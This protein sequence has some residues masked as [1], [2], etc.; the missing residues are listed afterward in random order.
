MLLCGTARRQDR[1]A[2][3]GQLAATAGQ[4]AMGDGQME[5]VRRAG[6]R[7]EEKGPSGWLWRPRPAPALWGHSPLGMVK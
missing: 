6:H 7:E 3:P 4:Q 1:W 2:A 5:E